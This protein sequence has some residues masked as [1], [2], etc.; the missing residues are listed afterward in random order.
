MMTMAARVY[1]VWFLIF[2]VV[3][4]LVVLS[5][6]YYAENGKAYSTAQKSGFPHTQGCGCGCGRVG[7]EL[8]NYTVFHVRDKFHVQEP[9]KGIGP[10]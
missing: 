2:L 8:T 7:R 4:S 3:V 6:V 1:A 9:K 10:T 5:Y